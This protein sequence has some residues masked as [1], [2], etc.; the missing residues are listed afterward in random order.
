[1]DAN[2]GIDEDGTS[3]VSFFYNLSTHDFTYDQ[4]WGLTFESYKTRYYESITVTDKLPTYVDINGAT[5]TAV[6]DPAINPDWID[7]GDGTV[8]YTVTDEGATNYSQGAGYNIRYQP[9]EL[10]LTFPGAKTYDTEYYNSLTTAQKRAYDNEHRITNSVT[11]QIVPPTPQFMNDTVKQ[12]TGEFVE[13]I[14]TRTDTLGFY[15]TSLEGTL[16]N[17]IGKRNI[18]YL[19][20]LSI[21]PGAMHSKNS[22]WYVSMKNSVGKPLNDIIVSDSLSKQL[23]STNPL[24]GTSQEI[25]NIAYIDKITL[26]NNSNGFATNTEAIYNLEKVYGVTA[27]GSTVDILTAAQV[28]EMRNDGTLTPTQARL[29][30]DVD[31]TT[32]QAIL[33]DVAKVDNNEI[34][35]DQVNT[36]YPDRIVKVYVDYKDDFVLNVGESTGFYTYLKFTD[37]YHMEDYIVDP[38]TTSGLYVNYSQSQFDVLSDDFTTVLIDDHQEETLDTLYFM[39]LNQAIGMSKVTIDNVNNGIIVGGGFFYR[40]SWDFSKLAQAQWIR[41]ATITDLLPIGNDFVKVG[42]F[43]MSNYGGDIL[44]KDASGKI[45]YELIENYNDSGRT[46][47][48]FHLKDFKPSEIT[49]PNK[50]LIVEITVRINAAALPSVLITNKPALIDENTNYSYFRADGFGND[51]DSNV[52]INPDVN[53]SSLL[54]DKFDIDGDGNFTETFLGATTPFNAAV[55][56]SVRAEKLIRKS[57]QNQWI[58]TGIETPFDEPVGDVEYDAWKAE[59][60]T[61][62]HDPTFQYLLRVRN[63]SDI[64]Y[65]EVVIYDNLPE[66][67]DSCYKAGNCIRNSEFSNLLNRPI[68]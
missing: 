37:P 4:S 39:K 2:N 27:S 31:P 18:D 35:I 40:I 61:Y 58:K 59:G 68:V 17:G 26:V 1:M 8:S 50:T 38:A 33:A 13:E 10:K 63:F 30:V 12:Y 25:I 16:G 45:V 9:V 44:E 54:V 29:T 5:R 41:N 7:N 14:I 48:I 3:P 51:V 53:A 56:Q 20:R 43:S 42:Q 21:D 22:T 65:D 66:V 46:A 24:T 67:G 15:P 57:E 52:N 60:N 28:D 47:V 62:H 55:E 49:A 6:F 34:T 36:N 32:T 11:A 64:D 23:D 19:K